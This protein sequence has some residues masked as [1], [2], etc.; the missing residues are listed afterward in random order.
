M[1]KTPLYQKCPRCGGRGFRGEGDPCVCPDGYTVERL[2]Q[3]TADRDR[4]LVLL[5]RVARESNLTLAVTESAARADEIAA[6][7]SRL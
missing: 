2:D 3:L 6:A 4:L 1:A 7:K 5:D